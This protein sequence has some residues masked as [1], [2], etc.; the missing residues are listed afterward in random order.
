MVVV[1]TGPESS[2]K[3]TL[4]KA[5]SQEYNSIIVNE[6]AREFL[7]SSEYSFEDLEQIASTQLKN[8][9][10]AKNKAEK[11]QMVLADTSHIVLEIWFE[12]RFGKAPESWQKDAQGSYSDLYLLCSPDIPWEEDPLREN[13]HDRQRLFELY[14]TKLTTYGLNYAIL[15]GNQE[16]R[17]TEAIKIIDKKK[18]AL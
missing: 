18:A 3:S 8:I 5:L 13:P 2:G 7:K 12:E 17:L 9:A 6:Y 4:C 1:I 15:Q 16:S 14:K 11:D 10:K